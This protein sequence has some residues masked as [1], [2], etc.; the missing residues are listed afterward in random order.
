MRKSMQATSDIM[1]TAIRAGQDYI[2]PVPFSVSIIVVVIAVVN[3]P[4]ITNFEI[5]AHA[6]VFLFALLFL[7]CLL[8]SL[9][10]TESGRA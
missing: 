1:Q 10:L 8:T 6:S 5:G 7:A 3:V 4:S 2:E 9:A